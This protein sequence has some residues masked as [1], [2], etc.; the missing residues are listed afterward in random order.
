MGLR[1]HSSPLEKYSTGGL[2]GRQR[3]QLVGLR[4][5]SIIITNKTLACHASGQKTQPIAKPVKYQC[6]PQCG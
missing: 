5:N 6:R 3:P 2:G 4:T 1:P